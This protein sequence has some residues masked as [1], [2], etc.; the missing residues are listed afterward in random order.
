MQSLLKSFLI[1]AVFGSMAISSLPVKAD[2]FFVEDQNDRF[3]ISF[4]DLWEKIGNQ[5]PD[6]KL[7]ITA[8]GDNDFVLCKVKVNEDRRFVIYPSK[9]DPQIQRTAISDEFWD[10]YLA[11]Y[12]DVSID[13]LRDNAGLGLGHASMVEA[14]YET[15]GS[16]I[17]KK[18]GIMFAS[19]YHDQ[20]YIVDCSS[21]ASVYDKWRPAF[22]SIIKS[23]D[24]KKVISERSNGYYRG[25]MADPVVDVN[26]PKELDNY[27]F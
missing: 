17:V 12:N 11:Q 26:G 4:P 14:S 19:L 25:F 24:F 5:N 8:P 2:I 16:A 1:G 13:R 10:N 18:R 21:E 20:V 27:K 23:V 9:F 6:D 22:L 3:T 15:S 7:T